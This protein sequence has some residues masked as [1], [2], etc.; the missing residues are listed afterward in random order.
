MA[1]EDEADETDTVLEEPTAGR[2]TS[3]PRNPHGRRPTKT[4]TTG[5]GRLHPDGERLDPT[6]AQDDEADE[7]DTTWRAQE[8]EADET[9]NSLQR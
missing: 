7:D 3:T 6:W 9:I 8:D 5:L 4:D 2:R 1:Q